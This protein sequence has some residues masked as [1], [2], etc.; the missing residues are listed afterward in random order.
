MRFASVPPP[1]ALHD[2]CLSRN[3]IDVAV[4][5][6]NAEEHKALVAILHREGITLYEW[7]VTAKP[8][9]PPSF[10]WFSNVFQPDLPNK[11]LLQIS[12]SDE[13]TLSVLSTDISGSTVC[14]VDVER[15]S[16]HQEVLH[17]REE[18]RGLVAQGAAIQ[19]NTFM[20]LAK[21]HVIQHN[22]SQKHPA[23]R[24]RQLRYPL[25][26][27]STPRLEVVSFWQKTKE[28]GPEGDHILDDVDNA[29]FF[30]LS[31]QGCLFVNRRLLTNNCTS[32]LVTPAHL[33]FTTTNHLLKFVHMAGVDGK[34]L[35]I[36]L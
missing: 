21:D 13:K 10:K 27:C 36:V 3:A 9:T 14:A 26:E 2:L 29:V 19:S 32:F 5:P 30:G 18:I 33:I 20:I 31:S 35:S 25:F 22:F 1:M 34:N 7:D 8:P 28:P 4:S 15:G 11:I 6:A 23:L 12:F 17:F 24:S 16:L